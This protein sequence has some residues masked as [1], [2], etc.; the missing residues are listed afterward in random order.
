MGFKKTFFVFFIV[1]LCATFSSA[2]IQN[3]VSY[4][5]V[6]DGRNDHYAIQSAINNAN[7]GDI[8]YFP[9]SI[10]RY[11]TSPLV[12]TKDR[13]TFKGEGR[14]SCISLEYCSPGDNLISNNGNYDWIVF[15]SLALIHNG[16]TDSTNG[17]YISAGTT[18]VSFHKVFF[19]GF[20]RYAINMVNVQH[21]IIKDCDF[22]E[23]GNDNQSQRGRAI[24]ITGYC[25][26][27]NIMFNR[28]SLCDQVISI[29]G[30]GAAVTF[31]GNCIQGSGK[32][33]Q[34]ALANC[35]YFENV[36]CIQVE[37]NYFE[38]NYIGSGYELI[39]FEGC[40]Q[41]RNSPNYITNTMIKPSLFQQKQEKEIIIRD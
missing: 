17:V 8:I 26:H 4:G 18:K 41:I 34:A 5:A 29:N 28:F 32:Y 40:S 35:L 23:I 30:S 2:A 19:C 31:Y 16:N 3:V 36:H 25:N 14:N 33:S 15:D 37:F 20:T 7:A 22:V 12:I 1:F 6:G 10:S 24:R 13:L 27:C 9:V 11:A 21:L 38:D 39:R